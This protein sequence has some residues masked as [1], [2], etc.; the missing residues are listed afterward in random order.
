MSS[1]PGKT[2]TTRKPFRNAGRTVVRNAAKGELHAPAPTIRDVAARAG[3][4]TA[5]VSNVLTGQRHVA[6]DRRRSVL[7]AVDPLGY[8]PNHLAAS[9]RRQD[10]RTIGLVVPDLTNPFFAQLLHPIAGLAAA[11]GPQ[12]LL[13]DN[14]HDVGR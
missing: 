1:K 2:G 5:T 4:A 6:A 14:S 7:E 9:P 8:Q 11:S 3:V 10:T 13:S 12:I